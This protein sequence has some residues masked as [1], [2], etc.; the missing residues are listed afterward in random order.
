MR[1]R[2][3]SLLRLRPLAIRAAGVVLVVLAL[4]VARM[5]KAELIDSPPHDATA[6]EFLL[7]LMSFVLTSGGAMLLIHGDGLLRSEDPPSRRR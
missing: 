6:L 3:A 2:F 1:R 7:A 4:L 5:L